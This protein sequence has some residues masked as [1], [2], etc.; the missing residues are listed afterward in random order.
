M[1]DAEHAKVA[2]KLKRAQ[3]ENAALQAELEGARKRIAQ[4]K[5]E[6]KY[7]CSVTCFSN[8]VFLDKVYENEIATMD[9][10]TSGSESE[11]LAEVDLTPVIIK[12]AK[13]VPGAS[14]GRRKEAASS[15]PDEDGDDAAMSDASGPG[16]SLLATATTVAAGEQ[17]RKKTKKHVRPIADTIYRIVS[18]PTDAEGRT[19]LPFSIGLHT[20]HSLGEVAWDRP[21]YHNKRYIMPI[22]FHSSRPYPST[23]NSEANTTW[24][25]RILDGGPSPLFEVTAEDD[26]AHPFTGGTSTGVWSAIMKQ[27]ASIRSREPAGSASGPDFFGLGNATVA[28]LIERLPG[29]DRCQQYERKR[30]EMSAKGH[31]AVA[32]PT[33]DNTEPVID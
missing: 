22:G 6:R 9:V 24:H 20:I 26:P 7:S 2:R 28:M 5:H 8:S 30:Y 25:S 19:I 32:V 14:R 11:A 27:A 33:S 18:V 16:T 23:V 4:L 29:A 31:A 12:S 3:K 10:S 13:A 1:S 15:G 21:A 17:A